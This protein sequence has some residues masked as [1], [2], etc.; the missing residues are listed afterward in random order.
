M[1]TVLVDVANVVGSR[2]DGWWRDRAGATGRLLDQLTALPGRELT[3]PGGA[4]VPVTALVAVVEGQAR[5]VAAPAGVRV[6]R[7][8]GSGDD[9]LVATAADL[10]DGDDDLLV[11]TADRG[12][13]DRLPAGAEVAGPGWLLQALDARPR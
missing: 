12:L 5:D 11:V 13:R 4:P 2:P 9:A 3:G 1:T 8:P 7:A 10:A 6:V